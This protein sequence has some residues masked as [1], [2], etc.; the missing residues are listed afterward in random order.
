M[1]D[2]T[3]QFT[4]PSSR[5]VSL[6]LALALGA[7]GLHRMY[8]GRYFQGALQA[9]MNIGMGLCLIFAGGELAKREVQGLGAAELFLAIAVLGALWVLV[10]LVLIIFGRFSDIYGQYVR[11]WFPEGA[12]KPA[13]VSMATVCVALV[14]WTALAS[15][16][17][18]TRPATSMNALLRQVD[19]KGLALNF[20]QPSGGQ[21]QAAGGSQI[22]RYRD[23]KGV[24]HYV[25]GIERV[26]AKYRASI[27]AGRPLPK[28]N[29][30]DF[31]GTLPFAPVNSQ[32]ALKQVEVFITSWCVNCKRLERFLR[33]R[34]IQ[35]T[36]YDVELDAAGKELYNKLGGGSVP[37]TRVGG[38]VIRGYE[39]ESI[40]AAAGGDGQAVIPAA[41]RR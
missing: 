19:F 3:A 12:G 14:F 24:L 8:V 27:E 4:S 37:I 25:E 17:Q 29:K 7:F 30:I 1:D 18:G 11:A 33:E 38:Q 28:I 34:G 35:Y 10:D 2:K 13:G 20:T 39:P 16:L 23:E 22:V 5:L 32:P 6:V 15:A 26:P 31:G 40:V 9:L 41:R 36:S 21:L